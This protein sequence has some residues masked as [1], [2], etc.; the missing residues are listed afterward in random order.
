MNRQYSGPSKGINTAWQSDLATVQKNL[1]MS[2][3]PTTTNSTVGET[4]GGTTTDD[5]GEEVTV[6]IPP[7]VDQEALSETQA[8]IL[9]QRILHPDLTQDQVG[10]KAG[11]KSGGYVSMT[12]S[13]YLT[14]ETRQKIREKRIKR[15]E[16]D[17]GETVV[18]LVQELPDSD[19]DEAE[20]A[21]GTE[22][23]GADETVGAEPPEDFTLQYQRQN[24]T[25]ANSERRIRSAMDR[26]ETLRP[27]VDERTKEALQTVQNALVPD[28]KHDD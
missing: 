15:H 14:D 13:E 3:K 18:R 26:I 20:G 9:K 1:N 23:N 24:S 27:M 12:V 19:G 17:D 16:N 6:V 22:A 2:S 10:E 5:D 28:G 8:E 11:C 4:V 7:Y 25:A 21:T